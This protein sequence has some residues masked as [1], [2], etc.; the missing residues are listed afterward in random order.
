M[1]DRTAR[2]SEIWRAD[3]D[4]VRGHEQGRSRPVLVVSADTFNAGPSGLVVVCPLTTRARGVQLHVPI[5]PPEGGLSE[6]SFVLTDQI[7]AISNER[8]SARVGSLSRTAMAAIEDR[9]RILLD[10]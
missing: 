2:R 4:P 3:L 10:L 9:L 8:L 5:R 1:E 7:R 6:L